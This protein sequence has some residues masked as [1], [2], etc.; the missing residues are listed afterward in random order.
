[1]LR[2][3]TLLYGAAAL[4][5]TILSSP[6]EMR[7]ALAAAAS[8]LFEAT[9]FLAA[10][11]AASRFFRR[12]SGIL[13]YLGCGCGAGPSARSLPAT[14]AAWF[15]FGAPVA[16]ARCVAA[17]L[18]ARLLRAR[19]DRR[20]CGEESAN[21]LG[22]LAAILPAAAL[23]GAAM[24]VFA[25]FDPARLSPAGN[26]M[27]G[28]AL[29]FAAAP[30]GLGAVALAGAL[31]AHAPIAA[32]AFLCVAGIVD[33]RALRS[34]GHRGSG[35][36]A[37]GYSL[38]AVALGTVA[39]KR[40][41]A[42]VHP[43]L[44]VPLA[45]CALAAVCYAVR[46]RRERCGPARFAPAVMLAGALV[47]AAPPSYHATETTLT[48]L[49]PGERLTFTGVLARQGSAS[50]VVRYAI[51]CCRA[52]ASP[53]AVR[54]VRTPPFPAGTWLRVD[55]RIENAGGELRLAALRVDR[56][57]PPSDPFIYR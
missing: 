41:D 36:D 16:I 13:E 15:V 45:C 28:A 27:L 56:V 20:R 4:S 33:L 43:A 57:A 14:A 1:L 26:A 7:S 12:G 48:D 51:T 40:G 19:A 31:R 47:G 38:L 6:D 23:T 3:R 52:D 42:L 49:F 18:A 10:G 35:H 11:I 9:P 34:R 55:G 21:P 5:L 39:A 8:A 17:L 30:C 25:R 46:H 24:Q 54:L 22:E 53:V 44:S 29:G 37:F 32:A 2:V 50:A